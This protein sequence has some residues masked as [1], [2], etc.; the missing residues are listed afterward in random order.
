MLREFR[1]ISIV[2]SIVSCSIIQAIFYDL[3]PWSV[4]FKDAIL[5]PPTWDSH[6]E[7]DGGGA[8]CSFLVLVPGGDT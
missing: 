8:R 4:R 1:N 5:Q 3:V 6:T 7:K 2:I